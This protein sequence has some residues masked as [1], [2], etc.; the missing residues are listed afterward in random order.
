MRL[1]T[2]PWVPVLILF[3]LL[4]GIVMV[5]L[6]FHLDSRVPGDPDGVLDYYHFHWNLWWVRH[7][8]LTGQNLWY[9]NMVLAP[10][11]HNLTYH[12]LT[13]SLLPVYMV[14]EPLLG[15][16][17]TANLIIWASFTATGGLMFALLRREGISRPGALLGG[18]ALAYSPYM[19]DHAASGHLNLLTVFWI[20]AVV[21]LWKKTVAAGC[22]HTPRRAHKA[23]SLHTQNVG[24]GF[25][26][27]PGRVRRTEGSH[28]PLQKNQPDTQ[29]SYS[30]FA[31]VMWASLTGIT[32]WGMWFTDT[33]IVL[34]GGLVL[35]PLALFDLLDA[36]DRRARLR[37]VG[38]GALALV[39]TMTLSWFL[40]PL[41]PTLDF[42]TSDLPPA[43]LLTSRYYSLDFDSLYWPKPGRVQRY[44]VEHDETLGTVLLVLTVTGLFVRNG[45]RRRWRWLIAALV[46]LVLALGP[47]I[48]LFGARIPMPF[49]VIY[50]LFGGQMRTP[51]RFLPP[52]TAA[53]IV[54]LARTYDPWLRRVRSISVRNAVT[55]AAVLVLL[56]DYG[57]FK[58]FPTLDALPPYDFYEMMRDEHY[59]DYDYVVLEVPSGPFTGWR[60]VG[61][62]PEA[63]VYGI[64]H[65]KRMVSGLL[66]RIPIHE[67][68][69]YEQSPL[70]GWL[71]G[72][73]PLVADRVI[74]ELSEIVRDWPVGYVVVH[75]DWMTPERTQ[76]TLALFN[77]HPA[78]C[79]IEVER[80]AVLY[81]T[82]S[83]P[84][85]C[86][87][88]LP[89][90]TEPGLYTID[91]GAHGDEG[92]IGHGWYWPEDVG[93]VA[94][95]W[96]GGGPEALLYASLPTGSAYDLTVRATAFAEPRTVTVVANAE[97]LGT[98]TVRPG[99]WTEHALTI[100]ADLVARAGG[101]LVFSLTADGLVSAADLGLSDDARPLALAYD[102]VNFRQK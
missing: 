36:A 35:G 11:T 97:P 9:T 47:D 75:Q 91:F 41:Q 70:M 101:D 32:L 19:L 61:S 46:P 98:F 58:R 24:A 43:R 3:A 22:N 25:Q 90:E 29:D 31:P 10:F 40:G 96:A 94:A 2:R 72:S 50:E 48:T 76:E 20:P 34:W 7:A 59:D 88:R 93:G 82:T 33:L 56:F 52:A 4:S 62:H 65:E 30:L 16:L 23:R 42:D 18:L 26:T 45:D 95:R 74:G 71:T 38:L 53:L 79:F 69:F 49:R 1:L 27:C 12:S 6:I 67:H 85:G 8:V 37:L 102:C 63:M 81:R 21:M 89:P 17:R 73:R 99:T 44:G 77:G 84:K 39:I 80:D 66:S 51:I 14:F 28:P 57:A 68:L 87:P 64:T 92:F 83:H 55:L 78:L 5:P 15:H 13:P 54:F 86:P 100:P 60:D